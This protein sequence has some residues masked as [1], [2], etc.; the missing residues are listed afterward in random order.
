MTEVLR[1]GTHLQV[2]RTGYTHHGIYVG[3]GRVVHYS[4]FSEMFKKGKIELTSID[5]FQGDAEDVYRIR[6][7]ADVDVYSDQE[8]CERA[9]SRVGEDNYNL[10]TNNCEHFATW[11]VTGVERSEQVEDVK[12]MTTAVIISANV[13]IAMH[14]LYTTTA[15]VAPLVIGGGKALPIMLAG[16]SLPT[17]G[18]ATTIAGTALPAS[19]T[20]PG[21][22]TALLAT[23]ATAGAVA[24]GTA[25]GATTATG[26][27][28]GG[29][30]SFIGASA[31]G[32]TVGGAAAAGLVVAST[33]TT[34]AAGGAVTAGVI[35][36]V[37][38]A[39]IL[40]PIA[41]GAA[42]GAGAVA[43]WSWFKD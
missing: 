2:K 16:A 32:A 34:V 13:I 19:A 7:S 39:P 6:Y 33:G 26:T 12:K 35:A 43:L 22:A 14:R 21:G 11:C 30:A 18:G 20:L 31:A 8:I 24:T 3:N 10:A 29:T 15:L 38:A 27:A 1:L 5:E 36:G 9:L 4:G 28:V 42:V 37:A 40:A 41:V 25:I 17:I 23:K